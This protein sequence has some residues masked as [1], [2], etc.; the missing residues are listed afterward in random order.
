ML[1]TQ[2]ATRVRAITLTFIFNALGLKIKKEYV[3]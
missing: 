2:V 3:L 1:S